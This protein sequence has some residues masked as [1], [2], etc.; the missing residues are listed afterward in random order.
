MDLITY[1]EEAIGKENTEVIN[2]TLKR[3]LNEN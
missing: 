2:T 3:H 1:A